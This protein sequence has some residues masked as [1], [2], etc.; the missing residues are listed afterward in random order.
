MQKLIL[1]SYQSPGD[2]V[3][4]TAAVR[5]L[6]VAYPRQFLT[7]V[8][9]SADSLWDHN[10]HITHIADSDK[11]ARILPMHYPLIHESNGRPYHFIHGYIQYLEKQ[12]SLRI[13]VTQFHGSIHL[14]EVE[15][16]PLQ[17]M[18]GVLLPDRYWILVAGGKYDF[19]AKWWNPQSAQKVV[20]Y[21]TG[22]LT[23]VQ[24]GEAGH[25][26]PKLS[27]AVDLVG[28]TDLR[29]LVRLMHH[30][31]GVVC[32]VT[33]AMHLAAAV[34]MP[35]G[36]PPRPCVV[37]AGGREPPQW[38]AYPHHQ[39]ISTVGMLSC[40]RDG[41]CWRSRCQKVGDGDS[42]DGL[43]L[44]EQ[45]VQVAPDLKIPR[46]L[47][48]IRPEDVIRRIEMY[49]EG[50]ADR[51]HPPLAVIKRQEPFRTMSTDPH[52][53]RQ[54]TVDFGGDIE[55]LVPVGIVLKHLKHYYPGCRLSLRTPGNLEH[56]S[57]VLGIEAV[58]EGIPSHAHR[59]LLNNHVHLTPT[60]RNWP[61]TRTTGWLV[62]TLKLTPIQD[63]LRH[64]LVVPEKAILS[65]Q[66]VVRPL[67]RE[68]PERRLSFALID[69]GSENARASDSSAVNW[70]N[71]VE[72]ILA[73]Q[74]LM[75]VRFKWIGKPDLLATLTMSDSLRESHDV[76][77]RN[78]P[79]MLAA[80]TLSSLVLAEKSVLVSIASGLPT[81]SIVLWRDQHP[82]QAV[83]PVSQMLHLVAEPRPANSPAS[84]SLEYFHQ[85]YRSR[86]FRNETLADTLTVAIKGTLAYLD[87]GGV[88][89]PDHLC[90]ET[91][92]VVKQTTPVALQNWRRVKTSVAVVT[93]TS[94]DSDVIT[95]TLTHSAPA[96]RLGKTATSEGSFQTVRF[97]HGLGDAANFARLIPLYTNR[98]F[99]IGVECTPDKEIL[100]KA[101]GAVIVQR[102]D[103]THPWGY[104]PVNVHAGHGLEHVGSKLGWNISE[105]P[106][107]DIGDKEEL[108][109]EYV[110]NKVRVPPF[111]SRRERE[112]IARWVDQ[113][114]RPVVLIHTIGNTNQSIKS[115]P[116]QVTQRF[117]R[118][119]L[120]RFDG[121]LVLLDWDNR[122]SGL[123]TYRVRHLKDMS[124]GCGTER[125]FALMDQ[126][127]LVVGVD[128]GPLHAAGLT[129]T[130][131]VGIWMPGHYPARYTLPDP[132]QLNLVLRKPTE[133]LNQFR[134]V[135]WNIVDQP[136]DCWDAA[137]LAAQSVRMLQSP[138][139][140]AREQLGADV[141]LSHWID[142]LCRGDRSSC[143]GVYSDRNRSFDRLLREMTLRFEKPVV[144]E[145]GTIRA[146]EDWAGAGF[147]TYLLGAY[148]R[149]RIGTIHSVDLSA[150]HVRFART[151]CGVFGETVQI[152]QED[153]VHFLEQ[154]RRPIDVLY[155]DS[156]DTT[157]PGHA[158]HAQ[159]EIEAAL[160]WL[161]ERS[162]I[163]FDDTPW[164]EGA[165]IGKGSRAVPW[166][167]SG[168]WQVLYAGYQVLLG[169]SVP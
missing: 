68:N 109:S 131:R 76:P 134:R 44:C 135:P 49:L 84:P 118:E 11:S 150:E 71:I 122:V 108:W 96:I 166:L 55:E 15:R 20:D 130:P 30:A 45:P 1:Q 115:L 58:T 126:A 59:I 19:T 28:K 29:Q 82:V 98:G 37:I 88:V 54:F 159:R 162:L 117:Y 128:S 155:L 50:D 124:G 38:E 111:V 61:S 43:N 73:E 83:E 149:H 46:C 14:D 62:E 123:S 33:L 152:H 145:T 101:V 31:A 102:A 47:E 105:P 139:Y 116:D 157:E 7:D 146:E 121:T 70:R 81:P 13:P 138:R 158:D 26:H 164:R 154:F 40:C 86:R 72:P 144:V 75:P 4:L 110:S 100:F 32:P 77:L 129:D 161:H 57:S 24:C 34:E 94:H 66:E 48:M 114:P 141:Q 12:L 5:D 103:T 137:W 119:L 127:D 64:D 95:S 106:L 89:R 143:S 6:H 133:H 120:D 167:L 78:L 90:A 42:E 2:I 151:W 132:L 97:H 99:R 163:L 87:A 36:R 41:G 92:P 8:R 153:S 23:F 16:S 67:L 107:P 93:E 136:G 65:V 21:F 91:S 25:W 85:A 148:L 79:E 52:G 17:E 113:L 39:F 168:G 51:P 63:L 112:F 165:F 60:Y 53:P 10:P 74:G 140:L 80:V 147:S 27:G 3:M 156:L 35:Q 9:T 69:S 22:R 125:M 18:S 160:P 104:P 56:Y 142:N 169:R